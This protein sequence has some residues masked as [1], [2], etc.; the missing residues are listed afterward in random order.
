MSGR[1]F[2]EWQIYHSLYPLGERRA[3][4]RA[5]IIASVIANTQ[6]GPDTPAYHPHDFMPQFDYAD[7]DDE[8]DEDESIALTQNIF[9]SLVTQLGG[10]VIG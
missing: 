1:E 5:G 7:A 6:R 3:D 4:L 9:E 10:E 8:V 2:L